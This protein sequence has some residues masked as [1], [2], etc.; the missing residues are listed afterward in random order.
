MIMVTTRSCLRTVR[1]ASHGPAAGGPGGA[2]Q[3]NTSTGRDSAVTVLLVV[4]LVH[5]DHDVEF[6]LMF[7][8]LN[9]IKISRADS[10]SRLNLKFCR[11]RPDW[12]FASKH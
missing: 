1:S 7:T 3:I 2:V 11:P 10:E 4:V 5:H 12:H 6:K 8:N 9:A